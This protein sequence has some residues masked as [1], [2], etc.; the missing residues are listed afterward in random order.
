MKA[1]NI[2]GV[3]PQDFLNIFKAIDVDK[4][5]FLSVNEFCTFIEGSIQN[6]QERIQDIPLEMQSEIRKEIKDLF[7]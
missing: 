6:R 3:G 1:L 7:D 5:Q 2:P 4:N